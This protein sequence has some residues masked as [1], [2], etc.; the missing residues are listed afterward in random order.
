MLS[1]DRGFFFSLLLF[2]HI[3]LTL[4]DAI[5]GGGEGFK[6]AYQSRLDG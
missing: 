2:F 6:L 4:R 3:M 5:G 1:I